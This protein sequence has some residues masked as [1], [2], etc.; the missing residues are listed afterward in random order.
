MTLTIGLDVGGTKIAGAVVD[1]GR[2]VA[3][4]RRETGIPSAESVA[5]G[6]ADLVRELAQHHRV[7]AVGMAVAGFVD[8]AGANVVYGTNLGMQDEPMKQRMESLVDLPVL[9]DNDANAAAW[10]EFRYGAG[11]GSDDMLLVTV[12]TGIGG[13]IVVDRRLLRGAYGFA[14]EIG[15]VQMVAD[16]PVCGCGNR[17]C[18]EMYASG[19]ALLRS[20]KELVASGTPHAARLRAAAGGR[21]KDLKGQAITE[22]ARQ[23]DLASQELLED[24]GGWLGRGCASMTAVLDPELIVIGGGVVDAGDLLLDPARRAY[25]RH[26]TAR[27]HRPTPRLIAATLGNDAGMIGAASIAAEFGA[28]AGRGESDDRGVDGTRAGDEEQP[29]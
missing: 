27:G 29:A 20:A 1:D 10:G 14:A 26:L 17:G 15:H 8:K 4:A 11:R 28:G 19:S 18:W 7:E 12:G 23:G 21:A 24:L 16:G 5:A 6:C 2:V 9:L 22:L 13:G 3:R 25:L